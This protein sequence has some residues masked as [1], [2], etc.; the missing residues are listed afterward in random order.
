MS[1]LSW[2]PSSVRP[3]KTS[4][5]KRNH[6]RSREASSTAR[7]PSKK[8]IG[9]AGTFLFSRSAALPRVGGSGSA[10]S[11]GTSSTR[12]AGSTRLGFLLASG[13]SEAR[14]RQQA[15]NTQSRK[16]F[17][18]ILSFHRLPPLCPTC[19]TSGSFLPG[20]ERPSN[21]E[22]KYDIIT[23]TMDTSRK[24]RKEE[25]TGTGGCLS[26]IDRRMDP[27]NRRI[28]RKISAGHPLRSDYRKFDG[29][30]AMD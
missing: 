9:T 22:Y 17:F 15:G 26:A 28:G 10:G 29:K 21:K 27:D 19:G 12:F 8:L 4:I 16:K 7:L 11:L 14:S 18:Q 1:S 20:K 25:E 30:N 24:K 3:G 6:V 2:N 13:Q 23:I 5:G